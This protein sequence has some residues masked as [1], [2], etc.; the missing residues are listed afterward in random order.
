MTNSSF[1]PHPF[2]LLATAIVGWPVHISYLK[3]GSSSYA[4]GERIYVA[5]DSPLDVQRN[6]ILIQSLLIVGGSLHKS[7]IPAIVGRADLRLRYLVLEVERCARLF[8]SRLPTS[9]LASIESYQ[10]NIVSNNPEHSLKIA[11]GRKS[12]PSPPKWYGA[13]Y[14][15]KLLKSRAEHMGPVLD[16]KS[17]SELES[18]LKSLEKEL[19][20]N[21]DEDEETHKDSFW[22]LLSSP[23]GKDG[24][25]SK[26]LKD[27]LQMSSSPDGQSGDS[28]SVS[29]MESVSVRLVKRLSDTANSLRSSFGL[30]S[31]TVFMPQEA[32]SHMYQ[33]WNVESQSYRHNWVSVEEVDAYTQDPAIDPTAFKLG[34]NIK[35]QRALAGLCLNY[36]RHKGQLFGDDIVIDR[37]IDLTATLQAG[38][39]G[40]ERVY[41]ANLKTRRDLGVQILVDASSSTLEVSAEGRKVCDLQMA[42]SWQLCRAFARLG[43]RVAMHG[44]HSWGRKLLRFQR[45][46]SFD[47]CSGAAVERRIQNMSVAGYTRCG[48]AIRHA[49]AQLQRYSGMPYQLLLVVSDGYPYDDQYEGVYAAEDTKKA[50]EELKGQGIA[51]VCLSVGSDIDQQR[52]KN[53]YGEANYLSVASIDTLASQLRPIVESAISRAI[54]HQ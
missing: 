25:L 5:I 18:Q 34:S 31:S 9:F 24:L 26:L 8:G 45:L 11:K 35:Y 21:D 20:D 3:E 50:L 37:L 41:Q 30:F 36:E 28:D 10:A 40:D 48:A 22:K 1:E 29:S 42:V 6:E 27:L 33:E 4:D 38:C 14:P 16:N 54:I 13:I 32:G 7:V 47:E 52:L 53:I 12:V 49:A 43:D 39:S 19:L 23:V 17:L 2:R 51:C 44:F 15:L 46:K